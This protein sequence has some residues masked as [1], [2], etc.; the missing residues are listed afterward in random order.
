MNE[1]TTGWFNAALTQKVTDPRVV[2]IIQ[3]PATKIRFDLDFALTEDSIKLPIVWIDT[4]LVIHRNFIGSKNIYATETIFY[5]FDGKCGIRTPH[6]YF[7]DSDDD[8][9]GLITFDNLPN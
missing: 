4:G 1:R 7:A 9:D 5:K 6:R 8:G 2:N 3:C